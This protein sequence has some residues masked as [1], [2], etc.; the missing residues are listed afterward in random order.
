[1]QSVSM[2]ILLIVVSVVIDVVL[3]FASKWS[4]KFG[5]NQIMHAT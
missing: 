2:N 3:K 5:E 4:V 1:M